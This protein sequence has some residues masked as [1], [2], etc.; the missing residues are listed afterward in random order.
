MYHY[1]NLNREN[2]LVRLPT[3]IPELFGISNNSLLKEWLLAA[4]QIAIGRGENS[5]HI[6]F[7][8]LKIAE[9]DCSLAVLDLCDRYSGP[10]AVEELIH[11]NFDG[12]MGALSEL[13]TAEP[14]FTLDRLNYDGWFINLTAGTQQNNNDKLPQTLSISWQGKKQSEKNELLSIGFTDYNGKGPKMTI[15][16]DGFVFFP[17]LKK[18]AAFG[19]KNDFLM[20]TDQ[21]PYT[22]IHGST[23]LEQIQ[24]GQPVVFYDFEGDNTNI[25][26]HWRG[27]P[28]PEDIGYLTLPRS[29]RA[30]ITPTN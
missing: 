9:R 1:E 12:F 14:L 8:G 5:I 3:Y 6:S 19:K 10:G 17:N 16:P 23:I 11:P 15:Y 13:K 28:T 29:V 27:Y 26:F 7:T 22:T 20:E 18:G 2:T 24:N 25:G 4:E 21:K 30:I